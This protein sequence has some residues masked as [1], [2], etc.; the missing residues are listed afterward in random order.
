[1]IF[2]QL[3]FSGEKARITGLTGFVIEVMDKVR[4]KKSSAGVRG[5][6]GRSRIAGHFSHGR[7]EKARITGLTGFVIEVMDKENARPHR[8]TSSRVPQ[9]PS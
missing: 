4:G 8:F 7:R 3:H 9:K 2:R 5:S 6:R 1:M